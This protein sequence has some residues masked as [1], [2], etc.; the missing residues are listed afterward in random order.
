M[1][2]E[3][4]IHQIQSR[5][6]MRLCHDRPVEIRLLVLE[7][8]PGVGTSVGAMRPFLALVLLLLVSRGGG[9]QDGQCF[10]Q[11][12]PAPSDEPYE[13]D[14]VEIE[15]LTLLLNI[16]CEGLPF[17]EHMIVLGEGKKSIVTFEE[18]Q[19][20]HVEFGIRMARRGIMTW[21]FELARQGSK[22]EV[23]TLDIVLGVQRLFSP[24]VSIAF[25][26]PSFVFHQGM[27]V[28][29]AFSISPASMV[30]R[31]FFTPKLCDVSD[32]FRKVIFT[33]P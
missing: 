4:I 2:D 11:V 27:H 17:A 21:T 7:H 14:E 8:L 28:V 29:A 3:G 16:N 20:E 6:G 19:T 33:L 5:Q 24:H 18:W 15:E 1:Q 10:R 32:H 26:P 22:A 12:H 30:A 31:M 13:L 25:P 9:I 23:E